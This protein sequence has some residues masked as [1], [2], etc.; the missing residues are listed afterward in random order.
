ME[1]RRGGPSRLQ[2]TGSAGLAY[3]ATG[4]PRGLAISPAGLI[5]GTGRTPGTRT[6]TVTGT[7]ASGA[8]AAITFVWTISP[9]GSQPGNPAPPK[10]PLP[11]RPASP[12]GQ[13]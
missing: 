2:I 4:L 12:K 1:S 5:T 13:A 9:P 6:V 10:G 11:E 7:S 3:R 8:T